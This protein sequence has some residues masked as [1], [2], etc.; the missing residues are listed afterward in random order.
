M[1]KTISTS[2]D[3]GDHHQCS[4]CMCNSNGYA[5]IVDQDKKMYNRPSIYNTYEIDFSTVWNSGTLTDDMKKSVTGITVNFVYR[6]DDSQAIQPQGCQPAVQQ[7][8]PGTTGRCRNKDDN[9]KCALPQFDE[10]SRFTAPYHCPTQ[11]GYEDCDPQLRS[12]TSDDSISAAAVDGIDI[13]PTV[14]GHL[15]LALGIAGGVLG[16]LLVFGA[17]VF[18]FRR[19]V[20]GSKAAAGSHTT[21]MSNRK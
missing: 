8:T 18:V 6:G 5:E 11:E 17:A 4:P 19:K 15:A 14:P 1:I 21:E 20:H 3:C 16:L 12:I 10:H 9:S 2:T 7:C 13:A